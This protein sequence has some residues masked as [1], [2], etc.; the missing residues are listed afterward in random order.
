MKMSQ[1]IPQKNINMYILCL[2]KEGNDGGYTW[3]IVQ[4]PKLDKCFKI[5]NFSKEFISI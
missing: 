1:K 2:I 5:D 3:H 4:K